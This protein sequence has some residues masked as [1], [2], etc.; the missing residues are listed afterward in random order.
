MPF[1]LLIPGA[2]LLAA[3]ALAAPAVAQ[4]GQTPHQPDAAASQAATEGP[5]LRRQV[6]DIRAVTAM[7]SCFYGPHIERAEAR[8][9]CS[10]QARG[11]LLDAA[12]AQFSR[13]AA[14]A[15]AQLPGPELR[16]WADSLLRPVV[17]EEDIRQTAQ[18]LAVR[19]T[20][21]AETQ[22]GAWPQSL[23]AFAANPEIRAA[24][25]AEAAVR[26][27]QAAE[28]RMA[29]VPFAADREFAAWEI[30]QDMRRDA[31]F[32]ERSLVTGMSIAQVKE[33]MG[34]PATLKQAVI[35]PE[36]Y[37]CAGYGKIW[38]VFRD[39]TLACLRSRLDYVRRYDTDC[40]CAGNYATILK[41]D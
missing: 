9:L 17:A 12:C 20:L 19:L 32:A 3:L 14:V 22:S 24:A 36:S 16:A 39:G 21:R 29:A 13:E 40:H 28:A 38:A 5:D 15:Q 11:K 6:S 4:P 34:N 1:R 41:N 10:L 31:A 27:R 30:G 33:L 37:L 7:A 8:R 18:G 35:G 2:A 23:A 26:D 25:L